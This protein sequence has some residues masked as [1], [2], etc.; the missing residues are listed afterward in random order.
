[1][2]SN[3]HGAVIALI[4]FPLRVNGPGGSRFYR[5]T[6]SVEQDFGR[7]FTPKVKRAILGQR[8]DRLFVRDQGR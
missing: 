2:R 7:I 8:A 1:M 4:D 6:R 3:D 5:D